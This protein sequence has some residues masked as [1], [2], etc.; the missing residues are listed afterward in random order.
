MATAATSATSSTNL[1]VNSIVSQLMTVERQP[2]NKLNV[3]EAGYQTRLSAYGSIKGAVASFQTTVQDLS[4]TNKFTKL[5]AIPSDDT[6]LSATASSIAVAGTYSL[7]VTSLAQ[8]QKLVATGQSSSTAAIGDGTATT[9]TFDFGTINGGTLDPITQKYTG[10]T[11]FGSNGT[12]TKS[13]TIDSSNNSLQGI[14]DAINAAKMGVTATII[15]DGGAAPY[16]LAL[17]SDSNGV[18]NSLKISVSGDASVS[19]LLA[20]DPA[21][22]QNLSETVT[23]KNADFKVNGVSV[24]KTSNSVSDVIQ[25][26]TLNLKKITTT[27]T[28]LTV[29]HDNASVSNSVSGFVKAYNDLAKTLRDI[30]AYN[31]STKQAA[32]LQGDS[33]VRSLQSQLRNALGSP[34]AGASGALT[35]LSQIGIS[36]QKDGSLGLDNNKLNSAIANNVNDIASLFTTVGKGT[37]S[38]ITYNSAT[39]NTKAGSYAVNVIQIAT[40]G[41]TVGHSA[42]NTT[43]TSANKE[44]DLTVNGVSTSVTLDVGTYTSQTLAAELQAKINGAN[45]FSNAGITVAVTQSSG[46]LSVTSSSYGSNSSVAVGGAGVSDLL[47]AIPTQTVG[48]DVGGS[49][50]GAIGIGSGQILSDSQGLNITINGGALGNRGSLNYSNGYA[51]SL[52]KWASSVLT[53]DGALASRTDG[54]NTSIKDVGSRRTAMETRLLGIEKRYRA[55]FSSLDMMLSSM[56]QTSNYLTQQLAQI[57]KL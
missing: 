52:D 33:T 16:R 1:D 15:N 56:N 45:T 36:F 14:R 27:P 7:E 6:I 10:V 22:T 17:S 49:I 28:T 34:V 42:A 21:A 38:L 20:Q 55:Q 31:P 43:I 32:I 2:I 50:G 46:V 39:S 25:G 24:S 40:Q 5:D 37:D 51:F 18:S 8:A 4:S 41:N 3:K 53:T 11:S 9:V 54:I 47:G 35:T 19:N 13:I 23:A 57:A 48:V 30:S 26:V 44:L 12:G 29:A